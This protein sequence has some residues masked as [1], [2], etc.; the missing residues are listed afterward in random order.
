MNNGITLLA[1]DAMAGTLPVCGESVLGAVIAIG[2]F[3]GG[4]EEGPGACKS[5]RAGLG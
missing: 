4:S 2:Q 1:G 3:A 5:T